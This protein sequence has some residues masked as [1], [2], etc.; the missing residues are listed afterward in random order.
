M[1]ADILKWIIIGFGFLCLTLLLFTGKLQGFFVNLKEGRFGL[2]LGQS[3]GYEKRQNVEIEKEDKLLKREMRRITDDLEDY[4]VTVLRDFSLCMPIISSLQS[5]IRNILYDAIEM[6]DFKENLVPGKDLQYLSEIMERIQRKYVLY[7]KL[8]EG[9]LASEKITL[10]SINSIDD[11]IRDFIYTYW[12]A[13]FRDAVIKTCESKISVYGAY[14]KLHSERKDARM[15][16]ITKECIAKNK[17]YINN[18]VYGKE[19]AS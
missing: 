4:L 6:N 19:E 3:Q 10:P 9:C 1:T 7:Q 14:M 11:R 12:I 16:S 8:G 17:R 15:I 13:P 2:Q 18:L 5:V